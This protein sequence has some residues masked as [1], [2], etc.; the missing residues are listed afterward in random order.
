MLG[1]T[2]IFF[3]NLFYLRLQILKRGFITLESRIIDEL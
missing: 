2:K 3:L 1:Q